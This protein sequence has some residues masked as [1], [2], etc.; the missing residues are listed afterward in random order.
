[1]LSTIVFIVVV[2][3]AAFLIYA[4]T[5]PDTFH[6]QRSAVIKAPAE[7]IFAL[8]NDFNGWRSWSPWEKLDP[9][10]KRVFSGSAQG[11]GARYGWDGNSKVGQGEMEILE[12]TPPSRIVIK[13]DFHKPFEAHNF[14]EFTLTPRGEYTSVTWAMYGPQP[15]VTK[16]MSVFCSMDRMVGPQFEAGLAGLT[17]LTEQ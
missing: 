16:L 13:L 14:A 1:M 15:F 3:I 2:V 5:R 10:L 9:A 4:A 17:K 8:I 7:K 12:T 11:T 6:I